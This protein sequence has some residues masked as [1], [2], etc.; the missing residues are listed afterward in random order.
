MLSGNAGVIVTL[1]SPAAEVN[2]AGPSGPGTVN[3]S[4]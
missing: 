2:T 1:H 4:V 3:D